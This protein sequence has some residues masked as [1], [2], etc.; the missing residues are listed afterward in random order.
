MGGDARAR[1]IGSIERCTLHLRGKNA[2]ACE[3]CSTE[4]GLHEPSLIENRPVEFSIAKFGLVEP[5]ATQNR[6]G[7]IEAGEIEPRDLLPREFGR[8]KGC[9]G[10]NRRLALCARHF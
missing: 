9:A 1:E 4:I 6:A 8:V 2:G 3:A 10:S 7:K 5:R